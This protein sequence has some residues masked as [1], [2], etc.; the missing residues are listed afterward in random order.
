[1]TEQSPLGD[2]VDNYT[3]EQVDAA[4][5]Y[6]RAVREQAQVL[7]DQAVDHFTTNLGFTRDEAL[8]EVALQALSRSIL[9][10]GM[11]PAEAQEVLKN[12]PLITEPL[13]V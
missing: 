12:A 2:G 3:Q 5:A 6:E 13:P 11:L 8:N 4:R 7:V 1:M 10:F 9:L